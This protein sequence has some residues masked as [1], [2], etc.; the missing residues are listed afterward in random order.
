MGYGLTSCPK[1]ACAEAAFVRVQDALNLHCWLSKFS[2]RPLPVTWSG[3]PAYELGVQ[4]PGSA[5]GVDGAWTRRP[6]RQIRARR[7]P[8]RT[9]SGRDLAP[10]LR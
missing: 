10:S 5:G 2:L 7:R 8:M 4:L 9:A 1:Q 6:G 3:A